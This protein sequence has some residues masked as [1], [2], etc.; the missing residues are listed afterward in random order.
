[1]PPPAQCCPGRIPP[2]PFPP[3]LGVTCIFMNERHGAL[4]GHSPPRRGPF[5]KLLWAELLYYTYYTLKQ[6]L[7]Y[8]NV[9]DY[10]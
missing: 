8:F 7:H 2:S 6:K 5:P 1:M 9:T 4:A 10:V 3:L